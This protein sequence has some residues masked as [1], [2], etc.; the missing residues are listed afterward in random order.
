VGYY[1]RVLE[2]NISVPAEKREAALASLKA[3]MLARDSDFYGGDKDELQANDPFYKSQT[4]DEALA[5]F[6]FEVENYG[7][8]SLS[9][10]YFEGKQGIGFDDIGRALA[11]YA[12]T[13][14]YLLFIGEDSQQFRWYYTKEN[15]YL[16]TPTITWPQVD[17][18]EEKEA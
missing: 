7:D 11:G 4:L 6:D 8:G 9:L 2:G 1:I 17:E 3:R 15:F 18:E 14:S 12:E 13:G 10:Y 16:Q 5:Y